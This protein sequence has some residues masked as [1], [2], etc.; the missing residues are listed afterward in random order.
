MSRLEERDGTAWFRRFLLGTAA[1]VY[2]A[3]AV[4]LVLVDHIEDWQQWIPFV[5][6]AAGLAAIGWLS[7]S[8]GSVAVRAVRVTA[9]LGVATSLAGVCLH[10]WG[11]AAFAREVDPTLSAAGIVWE[12]LA[13]G[14]PAVA[15]GL[16][17]LASI[18][19]AAATRRSPE[20][21]PT[22]D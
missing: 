11:N 8:R 15:P 1:A 2:A 17:A 22:A 13:G 7:V 20:R 5:A 10:L 3:V 16:V 14:N 12:S 6:V 21:R 4:E 18:L 19:A 9:L